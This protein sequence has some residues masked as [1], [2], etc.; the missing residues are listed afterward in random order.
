[1]SSKVKIISNIPLTTGS[2]VTLG[3]GSSYTTPVDFNDVLDRLSSIYKIVGTETL[4]NNFVVTMTTPVVN[5]SIKIY[6]NAVC[7]PSGF[8]VTLLGTLIPSYLLSKNFILDCIYNGSS[9]DNT[10]VVDNVETDNIDG[11]SI[12]DASVTNAKIISL[13][14]SKLTG[15]V[16]DAQI[17]AMNANKLTGSIDPARYANNTVP[18]AALANSSLTAAQLADGAVTLAKVASTGTLHVDATGAATTAV[19]TEEILGSYSLP[20][21]LVSATGKGI[22]VKGA[23]SFAANANTKTARIKING[24]TIYNSATA[25]PTDTAPNDGRLYFE[26]D[27]IRT[28]STTAKVMG[29]SHISTTTT[30]SAPGIGT[31]TGLD[32]TAIQAIIWAGQNGTAAANDIVFELGSVEIIL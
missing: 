16:S 18:A 9:W 30:D 32:F 12:T 11:L 25:V 28:G 2:T 19:T 1:M 26:F 3:N 5:T 22:R 27:L 14:A 10:I 21:N 15:T 7:I 31:V 29:M 20:A 17:A 13:A 23:F 4:L 8:T 6:W 24:Q